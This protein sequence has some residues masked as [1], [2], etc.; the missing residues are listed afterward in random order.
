MGEVI[1]LT[2]FRKRK[3]RAAAAADAAQQ[4]TRF[5]LTKE[6]KAKDRDATERATRALDEKKIED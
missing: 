1:N 6:R 5:G 3:E 4:R 2:R